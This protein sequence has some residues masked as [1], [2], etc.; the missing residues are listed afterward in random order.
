MDLWTGRYV[1]PELVAPNYRQYRPSI[2]SPQALFPDQFRS[3]RGQGTQHSSSLH[4]QDQASASAGGLPNIPPL[5]QLLE[6]VIDHRPSYGYQHT[7]PQP[8]QAP[9]TFEPTTSQGIVAPSLASGVL[10]STTYTTNRPVVSGSSSKEEARTGRGPPEKWDCPYCGHKDAHVVAPRS[11]CA[12]CD[13]CR[14]MWL[15]DDHQ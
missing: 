10:D 11:Q 3:L 4:E 14:N 8:S 2:P 7:A 9:P 6:S 1:A 5:N 15:M 13:H 12:F